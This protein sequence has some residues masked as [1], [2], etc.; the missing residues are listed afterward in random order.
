[1]ADYLKQS[2]MYSAQV[3]EEVKRTVSDMLLRIERD[4]IDAIRAYSRDLDGWDPPSF[5]VDDLAILKA[6][7]QVSDELKQH[8]AFAQAQVKTFARAQRQTL[9]ELKLVTQSGI[10]LG[11]RH[12]PVQTVGSYVPGGATRCSRR[13]S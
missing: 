10:T 4:G 8:I 9:S 6:E 1:M 11:H 2:P 7:G 5:I 13:R 12:I 3:T